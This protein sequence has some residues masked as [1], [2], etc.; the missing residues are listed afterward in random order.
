MTERSDG[1]RSDSRDFS[2]FAGII[3]VNHDAMI[4]QPTGRL[5][6]FV[7][8]QWVSMAFYGFR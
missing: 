2:G 4:L 1:T 3:S 7:G 8:M 5:V 6:G